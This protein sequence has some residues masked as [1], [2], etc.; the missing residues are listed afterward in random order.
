[1]NLFKLLNAN[2]YFSVNRE[3]AREIGIN[4]TIILSEI[5][6]KYT[7][8]EAR[9]QLNDGWFYLTVESVEE[10][11]T[12]AKDAQ[13]GAIKI[14]KDLGLIETK[15][16]GMPSKRHF[17]VIQEKFTEWVK[18][19]NKKE[20]TRQQDG[21]FDAIKMEGLSTPAPIYSKE[22]KEEPYKEIKPPTPKGE[23]LLSFGSF[24]KMKEEDYQ[25][26]CE[27]NTKPLIDI[28]I[29][30]IN[31]YMAS[32]GVKPYK[33]YP[34]TIRN[35]IRRRKTSPASPNSSPNKE[36]NL[37]TFR[38]IGSAL[39]KA[40]KYCSVS[41]KGNFVYHTTGDSISLDLPPETFSDVI[42]SWTGAKK[43]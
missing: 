21:G 22:T 6:D 14:L 32:K 40:G 39:A 2:N 15:Q 10:R 5:L 25:K 1:M 17:R 31:D 37:E 20:E 24:V 41:L 27:A 36:T 23:I 3:I 13:A 28:V 16:M 26:L 34:A 35:W 33:D 4:A 18:P 19:A 30:E 43:K 7:Y 29:E 9:G 12:L 11:T 42:C 8:F 38:A